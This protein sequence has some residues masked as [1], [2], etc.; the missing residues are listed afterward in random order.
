MADELKNFVEQNRKD[1]EM[2]ETDTEALWQGVKIG[3]VPQKRRFEIIKT[4]AWRVAAVLVLGIGLAWIFIGQKPDNQ[5][6]TA[7]LKDAETYYGNLIDQKLQI[8]QTQHS[9]R[10]DPALFKDLEALDSA[11]KE[12]KTDLKDNASNAEVVNAMIQHY[13]IKLKLL[14][15]ILDELE[16]D[17]NE[18]KTRHISL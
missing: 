14:E 4:W 8:I 12:L 10:V 2:F 9:N 6:D 16:E 11:C 17:K 15:N 3:L 7:E 5:W 18:N 1:F 13:R